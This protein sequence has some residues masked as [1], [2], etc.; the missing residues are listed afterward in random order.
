VTFRLEWQN[1]TL[2][3]GHLPASQ[4]GELTWRLAPGVQIARFQ[5]EVMSMR[6]TTLMLAALALEA[7]CSHTPAKNNQDQAAQALRS[8]TP[9]PK[10][11]PPPQEQEPTTTAST[12]GDGAPAIY[13]DFDS[14]LIRDDSRAVLQKVAAAAKSGRSVRI[15]GNCDE[16]GTTE[17]NLALGDARAR[18]A[19]DY[20]ARLG[21]PKK[22]MSQVSYGSEK[23][24]ALGHDESAWAQ[25]RRD[26]LIVR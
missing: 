4:P 9:Q 26:D 25:N 19:E 1:V 7:G 8:P 21:V 17:Y 22:R 18:A 2:G 15:E 6:T 10:L 3:W 5:T 13:F 24:K 11:I 12:T 20:L 14:S 16:R 23:P